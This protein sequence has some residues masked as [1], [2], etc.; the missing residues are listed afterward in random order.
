MYNG[1]PAVNSALVKSVSDEIRER[2]KEQISTATAAVGGAGGKDSGAAGGGGSGG[3]ISSR[4]KFM[5][6]VCIGEQRGQGVRVGN[7]MFWDEDTDAYA[8]ESYHNDSIFCVAT[9]Y[10]VYTY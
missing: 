2:L 5:V 7:R 10:G 6:N 9:A 1:D 8:S 4:Y 3:G